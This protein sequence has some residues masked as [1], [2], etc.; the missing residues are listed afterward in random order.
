MTWPV[1]GG[2]L[3]LVLLAHGVAVVHGAAVVLMLTGALAA[4][5]RPRIVLL[6]APVS[7]AILGVNLA[8]AP[9]PLTTLELALR[10]EAGG[11]AYRGG[12]LGHYVT[13]PLGFDIAATA[14]QAGIYTVAILPNA[15]AYGLLCARLLRD[16]A[17]RAEPA[18]P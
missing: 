5:R 15:L 14:T 16:R 7:A 6:H 10:A 3:R 1:V 11:S 17:R 9:C 18:L 2:T 13:E 8:G 4:L 12:F